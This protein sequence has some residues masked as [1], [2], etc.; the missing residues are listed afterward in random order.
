[1]WN[2]ILCILYTLIFDYTQ[3]YLME[4]AQAQAHMQAHPRVDL[5]QPL[6]LWPRGSKKTGMLLLMAEKHSYTCSN[7]INSSVE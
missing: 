6:D 4:Q 3:V 5:G 2:R 1:M 7:V